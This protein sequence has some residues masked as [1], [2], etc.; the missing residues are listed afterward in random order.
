M[1]LDKKCL[2]FTLNGKNL[3][4]AFG[5]KNLSRFKRYYPYVAVASCEVEIS[6]H[7]D[8]AQL[9]N[10]RNTKNFLTSTNYLH[11]TSTQSDESYENSNT[12]S[13]H[14]ER[15]SSGSSTPSQ[16]SN[17]KVQSK[18]I[19][20]ELLRDEE[21]ESIEELEEEDEENIY[22][23]EEDEES[24]GFK[25]NLKDSAEVSHELAGAWK[26][27][28]KACGI[29]EP[30]CLSYAKTFSNHDLELDMIPK[31]SDTDLENLGVKSLGH[32]LRIRQGSE[33]TMAPP[34]LPKY[35]P[36]QSSR[37]SSPTNSE[38]SLIS[39]TPELA[40]AL[41][42]REEELENI[43]YS[44]RNHCIYLLAL[45]KFCDS[46]LKRSTTPSEL[47]EI[48]KKLFTIEQYLNDNRV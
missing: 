48:R 2:A 19:V 11:H 39:L 31:L 25:F 16:S 28:F 29:G 37:P 22:L 24:E 32:R 13:P 18:M 36:P 12:S 40:E 35:I 5:I 41:L 26:I 23:G 17:S 33:N 46:Y 15:R 14:D 27:F 20:K 9:I 3:G 8:L 44:Y 1:D 7:F 42:G 21:K 38:G 45:V 4:I 30:A 43:A 47:S 10:F 34:L 6:I